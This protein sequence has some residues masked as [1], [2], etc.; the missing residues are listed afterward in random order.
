MVLQR[1]WGAITV[2]YGTTSELGWQYLY[3][4]AQQR[5]QS[6]DSCKR[7]H[8]SGTRVVISVQSGNRGTG[9]RY[10]YGRALNGTGVAVAVQ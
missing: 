2:Q 1:Y 6:G 9:M 8:C 4:R 5:Y 3:I 10:L 7:W